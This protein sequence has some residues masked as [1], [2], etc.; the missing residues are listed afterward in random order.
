M[1]FPSDSDNQNQIYTFLSNLTHLKEIEFSD[2]I[3][4][5]LQ[6]A[7][8]LILNTSSTHL[9]ETVLSWVIPKLSKP[10]LEE[11]WKFLSADDEIPRNL[12]YISFA[13]SQHLMS[14]EALAQK[15]SD[16]KINKKTKK[17]NNKEDEGEI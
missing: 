11:L 15:I 12:S 2:K 16:L 6:E 1:Q 17:D 4:F 3:A 9:S 5:G 8:I 13:N 10:E 14:K 7:K